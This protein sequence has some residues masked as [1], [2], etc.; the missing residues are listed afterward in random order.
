M[1]C[2]GKSKQADDLAQNLLYSTPCASWNSYIMKLPLQLYLHDLSTWNNSTFSPL[3]IYLPFK[4]PFRSHIFSNPFLVLPS[5]KHSFL[6]WT[7]LCFRQVFIEGLNWAYPVLC[8]SVHV[9]L[10]I[11]FLRPWKAALS[12]KFYTQF[13]DCFVQWRYTIYVCVYQTIYYL[14]G[15]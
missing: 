9:L 12:F 3:F 2:N 10:S 6:I 14:N 11:V 4:I 8:L 15:G 5:D 13:L 1:R 7:I